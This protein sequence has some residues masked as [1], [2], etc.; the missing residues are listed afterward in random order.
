MKREQAEHFRA[1]LDEAAIIEARKNDRFSRVIAMLFNRL[2]FAASILAFTFSVCVVASPL[3]AAPM[4]WQEQKPGGESSPKKKAKPEEKERVELLMKTK[5]DRTPNGILQAWSADKVKKKEQKSEEAAEKPPTAEITNAF[6]DFVFLKLEKANPEFKKDVVLTVLDDDGKQLGTIKLLT[7]EE[8]EISAKVQT[9]KAETT[10]TD[11][12]DSSAQTNVAA[13]AVV[14]SAKK[15]DAEKASEDAEAEDGEKEPAKPAPPHL[16]VEVGSKVVLKKIDAKVV[17]KKQTER[18]KA[19]VAEFSR[20]VSLGNWDN[21]KKYFAEKFKDKKNAQKI[22]SYLLT[23]LVVAMPQHVKNGA[24]K[25]RQA[26]SRG[27]TPPKSVLSP[28]DVLALTEASPQAISIVKKKHRKQSKPDKNEKPDTVNPE[29]ADEAKEAATASSAASVVTVLGNAIPANAVQVAPVSSA[30][31]SE[32]GV[33]KDKETTS[34][35]ELSQLATLLR[36]TIDVGYDLKPL[37]KKFETGTTYFGGDDL[38]KRL[39]AAD[40]LMRCGL[41][42]EAEKF[43]PK[44]DDSAFHDNIYSLRIWKQ[45]ADIRY[46]KKREMKW[47]KTVWTTNQ[48]I[49]A[50]E[51]AEQRD[52][53]RALARLIGIAPLLDKSIGQK[54]LDESFTKNPERGVQILAALG[55][56]SAENLSKANS[57]DGDERLKMLKLQNRAVEKLLE[58]SP[59]KAAQWGNTL[60]LLAQNW[61]Q[62]AQISIDEA[63]NA[64]TGMESDRYGNYY[65]NDY[66][67]NAKN[68]I[69]IVEILPLLPSAKWQE[70]ISPLM[71]TD[72]KVK[73]TK[74]HLQTKEYAESFELLEELAKQDKELGHDL[75]E[76]FLKVWTNINDPNSS[77]N[78][79]NSYSY[80]Y[81]YSEKAESIPLTRSKQDRSLAELSG[82]VDKIRQ[83]PIEPVEEQLLVNAF[84]SVHSSAEVY[85]MDRMESVFGDIKGLKPETIASLAQRMRQN[86]A[87]E[88]RS[89]KNQEENKTK[90]KAP[91]IIREVL[92]GYGVAHQ[93]TEQAIAASPT[94]WQLH[95]ADASLVMDANE[96]QQ[97]LQKSSDYSVLRTA[98][99]GMF[100]NAAMFYIESAP[101]L[102]KSEL[103]TEVFDRWFYAALGA[104]DLSS[105]EARTLPMKKE[106]AKIKQAIESLPGELADYH[107]GKFANNLFARMSPVKPELK[108]RYLKYGF[109]IAGDHPLAWESRELF[110]YYKDLIGEIKLDLQLDGN[111]RVGT[112]LFGV[113]VNIVHTQEIE[114]EAGGFGKY[115]TN[116]NQMRYSYNYGRPTEDYRDKFVDSVETALEDHFEIQSVTFMGEEAM[117]SRPAI[118][119]GWRVTPYAY[120]ALRAKGS[121]IDRVSPVSL[122]MDFLDTSGFVVIPVESP[123]LIVDCSADSAVRPVSDLKLTQTLDER[124]INDG[125][126]I[127]EVSATG[128]GLIPD[129]DQLIDLDMADFEVASIADQGCLPTSFDMQ[130]PQI[131]ILSDRSWTVQYKA[132][133]QTTEAA[134]FVFSDVKMDV[135]KNKLQRYEDADLV[136]A[137]S[138][139]RLEKDLSQPSYAWMW[140]AIPVLGLLSVGV[141]ALVMTMSAKP[142]AKKEK[143]EVPEDINAFTVLSLLKDIKQNNGIDIKQK[144]ELTGSINRIEKF[145]FGEDTETEPADLKALASDWVQKVR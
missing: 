84:V 120:I 30:P 142:E 122:D 87:G 77:R 49:F 121:E 46:N 65:W 76:E 4:A 80:F 75:A 5:F 86:L 85:Q 3:I 117:E 138:V 34:A 115:A 52:I 22:Y 95:L 128:R 25:R 62:E 119:R 108:Y 20:D 68:P 99:M 17:A 89:V 82:W 109:E 15:A 35:A 105:L 141:A 103:T 60:S 143:F 27:E 107:M 74:L 97:S 56:I 100:A 130:S 140:L 26:E 8:T 11:D 10:K 133:D 31:K 40:L 129:L 137:D 18:L 45:L 134:E 118:D 50:A 131:Q 33:D 9:K 64:S 19:E 116:Q 61:I 112:D 59:D 1:K 126:L 57:V 70:Q 48:N 42:D 73:R 29:K 96:F 90:R 106:F 93:L 145:Y 67:S 54:W 37:L 6:K 127:L 125:K 14:S 7:V 63:P 114:R 24:Q 88:W 123:E 81:G 47:L 92:R 91:E 55:S 98:S 43:I 132:K 111:N 101:E 13:E 136:E 39:T 21:V 12:A 113:Y 58:V 44:V 36:T 110:Q 71:L 32:K 83:L 51:D 135:A 41:Y 102:E 104:V 78:R 53:D 94:N 38:E 28:F 23:E 79:R 66:R 2:S 16:D 124:Q 144:E 139:I 72:I 69:K